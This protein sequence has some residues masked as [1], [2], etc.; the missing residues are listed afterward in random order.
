MEFDSYRDK[1]DGE[2]SP[3]PAQEALGQAHSQPPSSSADENS[4]N[5]LTQRVVRSQSEVHLENALEAF[6][7]HLLSGMLMC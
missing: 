1:S 7:G 5:K 4:F 2:G 6:H 3:A